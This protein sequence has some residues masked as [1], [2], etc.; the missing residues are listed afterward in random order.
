[1]PTAVMIL[2]RGLAVC[3]HRDEVWNVVFVCD[4]VHPLDVQYTDSSGPKKV[5]L[6]EA[7]RDLDANL[8]GEGFTSVGGPFGQDFDRIFN[9][10]AEYAH[11]AGAKL[12]IKRRRRIT[13]LV[14]LKVPGANLSASDF[15]TREYYVQEMLSYRG[16][17]VEIIPRV[18]TELAVKFE[19]N[20]ELRIDLIDP[21]DANYAKS[22]KPVA[23][24]GSITIEFN[25]DCGSR[26]THNDFLDLYELLFEDPGDRQ[27]A[28]GQVKQPSS[29]EVTLYSADQGNCDPTTVE[30]PPG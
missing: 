20:D 21:A 2:V 11:G 15:T 14:W 25:N 18:A 8:A 29:A 10:A 22:I 7:G 9:F 12:V 4:D 3:F 16:S 19:V 23:S 6:H 30:P 5:T 1:M 28:A 17:P 24:G 27:F 13:D 26:C